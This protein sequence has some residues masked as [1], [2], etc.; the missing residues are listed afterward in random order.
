M[1]LLVLAG[2]FGTRLTSAVSDVPKA[3]APVQGAPFL[4]LQLEHWLNQGLREFT[5]LLHHQADQIIHFLKEQQVELLRDCKLDWV[6]EP[7]PLDTGGAIANA[8]KK[9]GVERSFLITNADTWLGGGIHELTQSKPPSMAVVNISDVSRYGQVHFDHGN[10]VTAF[11]EKKAGLSAGWIN[12][13]MYHLSAD[14]LMDWDG[15]PFSLER[16]F[17]KVLLKERGLKVVPLEADFIDIGI[18]ADYYRFC[19]WVKS[20]RLD[21]FCN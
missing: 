10:Y 15:E 19:D 16:D 13:G 1:R 2:G 8:V 9:L 3:L 14:L 12:A 18:P 5:F 21:S 6:I 17:F 11:D 7:T 4:R 20:D